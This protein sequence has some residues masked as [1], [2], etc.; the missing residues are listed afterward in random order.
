MLS[1]KN[2]QVESV[3]FKQI[4]KG[5]VQV[6]TKGKLPAVKADY[7][8]TYT[9]YGN[10]EIDV[11]VDYTPKEGAPKKMMPRFGT[12]MVLS[13]ALDSITWYGPGPEPTYSDR[14]MEAVGTYSGKVIDQFVTTYSEPSESGNKTDVRWA[15]VTDA[16]GM[17]LMVMATDKL[18]SVNAQNYSQKEIETNDYFYTMTPSKEVFFNIDMRQ[19]GVAGNNSWGAIAYPEYRIQNQAM[20]Y[21][22][23]L[24]PIDKVVAPNGKMVK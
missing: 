5:V 13:P 11:K 24:K 16:S 10:G 6:V 23:R 19:M 17:G 9:V 15:A 8:F 1:L 14:N 20:S 12:A 18:L 3:D 2:T 4:S 7:Q 21:S 22:Y